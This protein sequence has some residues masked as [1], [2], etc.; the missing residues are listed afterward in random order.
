MWLVCNELL[1][2]TLALTV[3]NILLR[4]HYYVMPVRSGTPLPKTEFPSTLHVAFLGSLGVRDSTRDFL[5]KKH[6]FYVFPYIMHKNGRKHCH[7]LS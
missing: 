1:R 4:L 6:N 5:K 2:I 7:S 3:L